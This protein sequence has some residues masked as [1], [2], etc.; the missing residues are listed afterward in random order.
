MFVRQFGLMNRML[1]T[2]ERNIFTHLGRVVVVVSVLGAIS[3]RLLGAAVTGWTGREG[4]DAVLM[5]SLACLGYL[6]LGGI[7]F[8]TMFPE[9]KERGTFGLVLLTGVDSLTLL[10]GK[11][12][13]RLVSIVMFLSLTLPFWWLGGTFGGV[14]AGQIGSVAVVLGC[15]LVFVS[16]IGTFFSVVCRTTLVAS[17]WTIL[18]IGITQMGPVAARQGLNDL[19]REFP[20]LLS[21]ATVLRCQAI[22]DTLSHGSSFFLAVQTVMSPAGFAVSSGCLAQLTA[23]VVLFILSSLLFDR[24]NRYEPESP[25]VPIGKRLLQLASRAGST[26][27]MP[28]LVRGDA[29]AWKDFHQFTG[30]KWL[31]IVRVFILVAGS[32]T[33]VAIQVGSSGHVRMLAEIVRFWGETLIVAGFYAIVLE[34]AFHA[35]FVF[36]REIRDQT[37]DSLRML[38]LSLGELCRRKILGVARALIPAL[39]ILSVG[40]TIVARHVPTYL[41]RIQAND[42][43]LGLLAVSFAPVAVVIALHVICLMSL[44]TNPWI[45]LVFSQYAVGAAIGPIYL[46][47]L[48]GFVVGGAGLAISLC[49]AAGVA[50]WMAYRINR[51]VVR[52]LI[53]DNPRS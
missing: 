15:Y 39:V 24:L 23:A 34:S 35:A 16:Q 11:S 36:Q 53:D 29:I 8:A 40:L 42:V 20:W 43:W 4:R 2:D 27:R 30:G 7:F 45:S 3:A 38:P 41:E 31:I 48:V 9:E 50:F 25:V 37:W 52:H 44:L 21:P 32:L 5:L 12:L 22:L 26:I 47:A 49:I 28:R 1:R 46:I 17:V 6:S 19:V 13:G 18:V 51:H 10:A 33:F 14:S